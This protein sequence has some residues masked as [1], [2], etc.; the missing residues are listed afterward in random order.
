MSI[1]FDSVVEQLQTAVGVSKNYKTAIDQSKTRAKAAFFTKKLKKN[2]K[3][4]ANLLEALD[5][6]EHARDN[7][8]SK[9]DF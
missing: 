9:L 8:T 5:R 3:I 6:I 2:N 1:V 4:V 7:T